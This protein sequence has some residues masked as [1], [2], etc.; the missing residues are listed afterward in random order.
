MYCSNNE[1]RCN[2]IVIYVRRGVRPLLRASMQ[3]TEK[4]KW[5][6]IY[7]YTLYSSQYSVDKRICMTMQYAVQYM[8]TVQYRGYI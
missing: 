1:R 8:Y 6:Y 5:L 2:D 4:Q 7:N 3:L